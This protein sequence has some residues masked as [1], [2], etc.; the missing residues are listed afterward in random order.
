M[1]IGIRSCNLLA[2]NQAV[3]ASTTLVT[4]TGFS[5]AIKTGS[6][7]HARAWVPF[8]LGAT[9]GFKFQWT[10]SQTP[11]SLLS[12]ILVDDLTT[13]GVQTVFYGGLQ[14]SSTS[15]ANAAAVAGNYLMMSEATLVGNA[16]TAGTFDLQF[17]CNS[18]ANAITALAGA[19]VEWTQL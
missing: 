9:G 5:F 17:A 3:S 2:A 10:P 19:W 11:V 16:S 8:T 15:F 7:V 18:A 1:S 14:T 12:S 13:S 6:K 4:V